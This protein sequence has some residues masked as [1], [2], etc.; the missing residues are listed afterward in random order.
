MIKPLTS[1]PVIVFNGFIFFLF[2][3]SWRYVVICVD[4]LVV[5]F[6][7]FNDVASG[8]MQIGVYAWE[9]FCW[10][11]AQEALRERAYQ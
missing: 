6:L 8:Y 11:G 2:S 9:M 5:S 10:R 7:G 1:V 3:L 4:M